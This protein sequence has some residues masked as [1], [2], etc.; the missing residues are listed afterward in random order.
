MDIIF[1]F[2]DR[3]PKGVKL[4]NTALQFHMKR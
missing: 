3:L 2:K 4:M 1:F